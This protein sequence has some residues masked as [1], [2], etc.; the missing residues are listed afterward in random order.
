MKRK[1]VIAAFLVLCFVGV[2]VATAEGT[3][4]LLT[5]FYVCI[6][7]DLSMNLKSDGTVTLYK[8]NSRTT[9]HWASGSYR[10]SSDRGSITISF[11]RSSGDLKSLQGMSYG[12]IIYDNESFGNNT[13]HWSYRGN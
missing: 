9:G 1:R 7:T 6:G 10:I 4:A 12:Y 8:G 3:R 11:S 5:G 13:E 2:G